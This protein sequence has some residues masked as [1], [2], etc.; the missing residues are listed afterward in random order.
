MEY[1]NFPKIYREEPSVLQVNLGYK[2]NQSCSHCH[3]NASPFRTE[4][5]SDETISC[6]PKAIAMYGFDVL[7]I[8]GGAPEMHRG[9]KDLVIEAT[10]LNVEIIDRSNLTILKEPGYEGLI[11]FLALNKVKIVASL[12][13]YLES[14]VDSQRGKGVFVKSI[15]ALKE[16]NNVGYGKKNSNLRI[17]I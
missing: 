4:M 5:M 9:F 14:N 17:E 12:P 8:T 11:D 7:D 13:C 16:L 2:C 1:S 6:I 10:K 3:V 15:D